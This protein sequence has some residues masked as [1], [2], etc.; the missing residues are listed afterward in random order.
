[1][2]EK[3]NELE[4]K[5]F[6]LEEINKDPTVVMIAKR[7]PTRAWF[8]RNDKYKNWTPRS[9]LDFNPVYDKFQD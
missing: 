1:M 8:V 2:S 4:I 7:G 6:K 9:P 5:K 3:S